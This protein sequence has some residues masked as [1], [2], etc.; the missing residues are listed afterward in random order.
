M[1]KMK[2]WAAVLALS[3]ISFSLPAQK[4]NRVNTPTDRFAGLDTAFER[5]LR[6]FHAA[7][8]AVAVVEK[9]KIVYAKGFGYRDLEKKLP[10]TPNTLFAIGSCTKAFTASLMGQLRKDGKLDFDKP[11]L[12]YLPALHFYND[13]MNRMITL[14][15][16]MS[17]RTGLPRHDF[18]WYIF[19]ND[20][21]DSL[22]TRIRYQ[23]PSTGIRERWQYNNF[24]FLAQGMVAEKI[25][26]K[27]WEENIST[28]ILKPLGMSRSNFSIESL[29]KD[30]D[31]SLGY[32]LK[33]DSIIDLLDY[34][35]INAMGP[36]GSINSSVTEMANWV[37]TWIN[38]G[39]FNGK[40]I[41]PANYV[42]EA[43]SPQMVA[44]PGLPSAEKPDLHFST[45]GL[46]WFLSSYK[47]HF[48]VEHGG[49]I[50]GFSASTSFFP[51]DSIGI[52][53]LTNQN[54]SS[55]NGVVRNI[56]ADRMLGLPYF[57]WTSDIK[58][59]TDKALAS[60]K[61]S[62][63]SAASNQQSGTTPSHPLKDYTGLYT[64]PG[65]GTM[66]LVLKN[67]SLFMLTPGD[68]T[69]LRHYHY[70]IFEPFDVNKKTGIDTS[71]RSPLRLQFHM[72]ETGEINA[73]TT[74]FEPTLAALRFTRSPKLQQVSSSELEKYTGEYILSG[75]TVKVSV[76]NDKL[77]VL[78]PGQPEYP[79][80]ALGAHKFALKIAPGYYVQF[81]V[82]EKGESTQL[83][84]MQPN[85]NFAAKRKQ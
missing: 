5:V 72:S 79:L 83:T 41:L 60:A 74:K 51:T 65:Y 39:K 7:G 73:L 70:D 12:N 32:G 56:L 34:Y 3:A 35:H 62:A 48:R 6:E 13:D 76:K 49:N 15:D 26:G 10:V 69:W 31:A 30:A 54:G 59:S 36:A 8:M 55:V 68:I 61:E 11:V 64:H 9:D 14:R 78:I 85:G 40:E 29:Q 80:D 66:D 28:Q 53:V 16:M 46:G 63:R 82:N 37:M 81:D 2:T 4:K 18:S 38:G 21:R 23:E 22:L 50:D 84:F 42:S 17:H 33:K 75:A 43:I 77:H 47:S 24:M 27:S 1:R 25:T 57:D 44:G 52:I 71:Q 45:Y 67:D 19:K 58:K 20:S